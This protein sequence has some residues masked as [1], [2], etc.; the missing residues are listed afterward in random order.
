MFKILLLLFLL[1]FSHSFSNETI[2]YDFKIKSFNIEE[3]IVNEFNDQ[4]NIKISFNK[5]ILQDQNIFVTFKGT[6]KEDVDFNISSKNILVKKGSSSFVLSLQ[7]IRDLIYEDDKYVDIILKNELGKL[8]DKNFNN[9][10][11]IIED[12]LSVKGKISFDNKMDYITFKNKDPFSIFY[13]NLETLKLNKFNFSRP[14]FSPQLSPDG[15]KIFYIQISKERFYSEL[16]SVNI[17]DNKRSKITSKKN[18]D[19]MNFSISPNGNLIS[20]VG[21]VSDTNL[22]TIYVKSLNSQY[23][24]IEK[25]SLDKLRIYSYPVFSSNNNKLYYSTKN[26]LY[27]YNIKKKILES[28]VIQ[29]PIHHLTKD[30]LFIS[31]INKHY[32][33]FQILDK[34][35][36]IQQLTFSQINK[37]KPSL[38]DNV[39]QYI[40]SGIRLDPKDT[41]L[42]IWNDLFNT[43][44]T[45]KDYLNHWGRLSWHETSILEFLNN[46]SVSYN[47]SFFN[48]EYENRIKSILLKMDLNSGIKDYLGKSN[49][50]WSASRYS[51]D[52]KS[53]VRI[54]ILDSMIGY[55]LAKFLTYISKQKPKNNNLIR[56]IVSAIDCIIKD[57]KL[58][59]NE[60][61]YEKFNILRQGEAYIISKYGSPVRND[62][63]NVP[64]NY[65]SKFG[66]LLME[67]YKF[68][69]KKLYR[70]DAIKLLNLFIRH[71]KIDNGYKWNYTYG[72]AYYG[73]TEDKKFSLNNPKSNGYQSLAS[74]SYRNIDI[75]FLN[76]FFNEK[77]LFQIDEFV[78]AFKFQK[79]NK[80]DL[81]P[82]GLFLKNHDE[83]IKKLI[84]NSNNFLD[85]ELR[86]LPILNEILVKNNTKLYFDTLNKNFNLKN[87]IK[88]ST[89]NYWIKDES[90]FI[91]YKSP[92]KEFK[93]NKFKLN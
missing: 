81:F 74:K 64:F 8:I 50:G 25:I 59:W 23:E 71:L 39:I 16:W 82:A 69:N 13:L 28:K 89:L 32:Q 67:Y 1:S 43:T 35:F 5:A 2:I 51:I 56:N 45:Y 53:M 10:K 47:D 27:S 65:H 26:K 62:G 80:L 70:E 19:V 75:E 77:Y 9:T 72:P 93:L 34:D 79:S 29:N 88:E 57:T 18:G 33:V 54:S 40:N 42:I 52:K 90:I 63:I 21:Y 20:F 44:S 92:N 68:N 3:R 61:E 83:H 7:P 85:I 78:N 55:E 22:Q 24:L 46:A 66:S 37:L 48:T 58:E 15:K 73:W 4:I 49:C 30:G 86:Y 36:T 38:K 87:I 17:S 41:S 60:Y 11:I 6:A 91:L 76:Y 31:Y 12:G 84:L 14:V